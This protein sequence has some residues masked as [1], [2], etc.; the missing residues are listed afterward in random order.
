MEFRDMQAELP[1]NESKMAQAATDA[2]RDDLLRQRNGVESYL[3]EIEALSGE[4]DAL[5]GKRDQCFGEFDADVPSVT[6]EERAHRVQYQNS[7]LPKGA[8]R[9]PVGFST[10]SDKPDDIYYMI[11]VNC[12]YRKRIHAMLKDLRLINQRRRELEEKY[13]AL[14]RELSTVT[15]LRRYKAVKGDEIDEKFAEALNRANLNLPVKR[16][17]VGK[18]LFG[19]RQIMAKII[20]GKLVI[21]VGGGYMSV[22]EFIDQY[23]KIELLKLM[24]AE[25]DPMADEILKKG[26][27]ARHSTVGEKRLNLEAERDGMKAVMAASTKTYVRGETNTIQRVSSVS[28][29]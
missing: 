19:T 10:A 20:N 21:R 13:A 29:A 2:G 12:T 28:S 9:R 17:A 27:G 1:K 14:K 5:Q 15:V 18:Y 4:V 3:A 16:L 8:P 26:G 23:G 25:G 7:Q 11:H 24:K 6:K 22:D